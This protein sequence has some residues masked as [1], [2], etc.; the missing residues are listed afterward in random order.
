MRAALRSRGDP[1][2]KG[3]RRLRLSGNAV[4]K[5]PDWTGDCIAPLLPE[6]AQRFPRLI[7]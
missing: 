7:A 3:P 2:V 6:Y 1:A 4:K 5:L